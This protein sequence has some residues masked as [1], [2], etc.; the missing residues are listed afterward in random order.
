MK[1]PLPNFVELKK[2]S[3]K[4]HE[5][6]KKQKLAVVG[7][8]STQHISTAIQGYAYYKGINLEVY[9]SLYNQLEG[10]FLDYSS[11]L[12]KFEPDYILIYLS[13]ED[14]YEKFI[15]KPDFKRS[16]FAEDISK[17]IANY[18]Q[19]IKKY[20]KAKIIQTLIMEKND[21]VFGNF[22]STQ[23]NSF[24]YQIRLLNF[25]ISEN[26][27]KSDDVYILDTLTL[28]AKYGYDSIFDANMYYIGKLTL[29]L[30]F[31]PVFAKMVI[32]IVFAIN[33]KIKK[34]LVLDLDNTLWGGVIGDD[35]LENIQI[36]DIGIGGIYTDIQNYAKELK[37]RGIILAVCSKNEE[38]TAK[39]PFE[40]HPDMI[41][42]LDDIA[43]FIANWENKADN[44]KNIQKELNIGMD[45]I[46]FI[47]DNKFER[48][49][50]KEVLPDVE[51]PDLPDNPSFYLEYIKSLNLFE[52][53]SY[54]DEDKVRAEQYKIEAK[55]KSVEQSYTD[56]T[57]YLK[58]LDMKCISAEF[59]DFNTSRIAQLTQRSNQFN[60]RTVRYTVQDVKDIINSK[61]RAGLY[62]KLSDKYGDYG[63]VSVV[64]LDI[65]K[66][67]IFIDTYLMSCRALK[68]G[69]EEYVINRIINYAKE[70]NIQKIVGEYIPTQKNIIVKNLYK[71]FG[72][73]EIGDN[74]WEITTDDYV[75]KDNYIQE[76]DSE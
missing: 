7:N 10:Q 60:L 22:A 28:Q 67:E 34:C 12:Y 65:K 76:V 45:S 48:N 75:Y 49:L 55:R 11:S 42:N 35:G 63:L 74:K 13:P 61:D 9:D 46:V 3:K 8:S 27:T 52:T 40:K 17:E 26:I 56:Y 59:D 37:K 68:R 62:F 50:V 1:L 4:H 5:N 73:R 33:G 53:I 6:I 44:I 18:W 25:L 20:S 36:G 66:D 57:S 72:F 14:L 24:V 38:S 31:L 69:L 19:S 30:D 54:S 29:S 41:L 2:Y 58:D 23:K 51:V 32:D 71:D 16:Q 64:I 43:I 21:S 39:K 15:Q 70:K 47:D